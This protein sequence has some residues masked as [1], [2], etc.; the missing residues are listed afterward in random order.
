[1]SDPAKH[2]TPFSDG[3]FAAFRRDDPLMNFFGDTMIARID[4]ATVLRVACNPQAA[5]PQG[6]VH[7]GVLSSICDVGMYEAAKQVLDGECVTLNQ[8]MKFL[9]AGATGQPL[10]VICKIMKPGRRVVFTSATVVQADKEI[11]TS[12]A[13]WIPVGS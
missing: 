11:A 9:R 6:I 2:P 1:M 13:Q 10:H 4:G 3:D 7:G 5:N 8:E 12:T